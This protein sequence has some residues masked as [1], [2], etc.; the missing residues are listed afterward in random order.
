M[1]EGIFLPA[2]QS[3]KHPQ[4]Q[5]ISVCKLWLH[6]VLEEQC[7]LLVPRHKA[8]EPISHKFEPVANNGKIPCRTIVCVYN[9]K[10]KLKKGN[11]VFISK[12]HA[13]H[14]QSVWRKCVQIILSPS[15]LLISPGATM[16]AAERDR[17]GK[18]T[19]TRWWRMFREDHTAFAL[20][21]STKSDAWLLRHVFRAYTCA[22][23]H[24][25]AQMS[26]MRQRISVQC[27]AETHMKIQNNG[28][29]T[30]QSQSI[31]HFACWGTT[32]KTEERR[33]GERE[34]VRVCVSD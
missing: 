5:L 11:D 18:N 19:E 29:Q 22:H 7:P 21:I 13:W 6:F 4:L 3:Y 24:T 31:Q 12:C 25:R 30:N 15:M 26:G 34:K 27:D 23:I 1:L 17:Q 14:L 8:Y 28:K 10:L 16:T 2:L 33:D 20:T 32:R 9:L